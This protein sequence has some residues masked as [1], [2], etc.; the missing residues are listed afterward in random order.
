[1]H[2]ICH[3]FTAT[4]FIA[5]IASVFLGIIFGALPGIGPNLGCALLLSITF[6]L[7]ADTALVAL[8]GMYTGAVYGGSSTSILLGIPGSAANSATVLDGYPMSRKGKAFEALGAATCASFLGGVIGVVAL[9]AVSPLLTKVALSFGPPEYFMLGVFSLTVI[10]VLSRKN[11]AKGLMMS[12]FGLMLGCVGLDSIRG[13]PRYTFG[14]QYLNDGINYVVV[15]I[16]LFAMSEVLNLSSE[17]TSISRTGKLLGSVWEGVRK[18]FLYPLTLIRSSLIGIVGG[19]MPGIGGA[20]LNIIAYNEAMRAS[21]APE[22]FGTGTV[23]GVIAPESSNNASVG[24]TM[25]PTLTLGIPGNS[26]AAIIMGGIILHGL[27]PGPGLFREYSTLTYTF[28]YGLLTAQFVMLVFGLILCKWAA[29]VTKVSTKYLIPLI[30]ILCFIGSYGLH[31]NVI[32][33]VIM[34]IFGVLG[35]LLK[36]QDYP[37]ICLI[38]GMILGV[39]IE[40]GLLRSLVMSNGSVMIFFQRPISL[41]I[42]VLLLVVMIFT[43]KSIKQSRTKAEQF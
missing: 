13:F 40:K 18:T 3:V 31:N 32:D 39:I 10:P 16:G 14:V 42:F 21:K 6:G 20:T 19:I 36:K 22:K 11:I 9:F 35:Y 43:L 27:V 23:E 7:P 41:G 37:F 1:M 28:L 24:A 26:V 17:K 15:L 34:L 8:G 2:P 5:L 38:L 29:T 12:L 25:I 4:N 30:I 33:I